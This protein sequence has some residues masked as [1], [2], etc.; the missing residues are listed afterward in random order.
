[1]PAPDRP[2]VQ[3]VSAAALSVL[4]TGMAVRVQ[5]APGSTESGRQVIPRALGSCAA[6]AAAS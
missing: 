2:M 6:G 1:M 3:V 5:C 4:Q